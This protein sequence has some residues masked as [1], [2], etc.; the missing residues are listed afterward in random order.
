MTGFMPTAYILIWPVI[1]LALL[2]YLNMA[3]WQE[4]R[5]ARADGRPLV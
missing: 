3:F 2:V 1:V 4:W 5:M